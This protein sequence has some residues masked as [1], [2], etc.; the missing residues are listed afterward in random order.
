MITRET[1]IEV[2]QKYFQ[3]RVSSAPHMACVAVDEKKIIE[4]SFAWILPWNDRRYLESGDFRFAIQ[5]GHNPLV[6]LKEDGA[7]MRLPALWFKTAEWI[8]FNSKGPHGKIEH[9]IEYLAEIMRDGGGDAFVLR[10]NL[11]PY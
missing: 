9:R 1:A 8:R 7:V 10:R 4:A 3:E 11:L 5:G 2:A 6:V